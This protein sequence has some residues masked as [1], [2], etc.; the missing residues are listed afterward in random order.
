ML[1]RIVGIEIAIEVL[2]GK[3]KLSQNK[4][5]R[6]R[7]SAADTLA[8]RGQEELARAMRGRG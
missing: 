2:E 8:S 1:S 7:L 6:D 5:P 4:E 3:S